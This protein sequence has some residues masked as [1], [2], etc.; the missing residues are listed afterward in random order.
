MVG[1]LSYYNMTFVRL[2][3][4]LENGD[5]RC[6]VSKLETEYGVEDLERPCQAV[7]PDNAPRGFPSGCAWCDL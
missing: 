7:S 4:S 3:H 1:I 5:W 2:M 6:A